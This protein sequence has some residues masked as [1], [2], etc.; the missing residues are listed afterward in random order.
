M[1]PLSLPSVPDSV[2]RAVELAEAAARRA[3]LP[4]AAV[5]RVGLATGE[6]VANAVEHGNAG[7]ADQDVLV[8]LKAS[9][10]RLDV[11]VE[12]HGGGVAPEALTDAALPVDPLRTDGRGLFLIRELTD[13]A[14][15]NGSLVRLTFVAR[16]GE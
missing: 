7:V 11:D 2:S 4:D 16:A 9:S 1:T 12:D 5:I 8:S 15:V 3:G 13:E 14:S 10:G 6:A